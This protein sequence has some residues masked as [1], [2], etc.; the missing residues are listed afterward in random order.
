MLNNESTTSII[1]GILK[2]LYK[3]HDPRVLQIIAL[4]VKNEVTREEGG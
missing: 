2:D 1:E 3:L 4:L